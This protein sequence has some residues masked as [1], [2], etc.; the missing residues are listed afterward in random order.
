MEQWDIYDINR[1]KT[2]RIMNRGEE[3]KNG[4]YHLGRTA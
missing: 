1:N 4:E 2:G 3:L